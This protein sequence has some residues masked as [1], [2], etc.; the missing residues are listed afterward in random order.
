M[1]L[2]AIEYAIIRS[3]ISCAEGLTVTMLTL[4]PLCFCC[5]RAIHE[6]GLYMHL[7]MFIKHRLSSKTSSVDGR[8]TYVR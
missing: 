7:Y 2:K 1:K 5:D 8:S 4:T 6:V 3:N